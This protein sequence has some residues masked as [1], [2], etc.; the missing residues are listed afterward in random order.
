MRDDEILDRHDMVGL[1][2]V[3]RAG[4]VTSAELL[5]AVTRRVEERNPVLNAV[6]ATRV[7]AA[8]AEVA[9]GLPDGPLRGV[10]FAVKDLLCDVAGMADTA[11]CRL[12]A[13]ATTERDGLLASRYRRAGLV[14]VGKTNTAE[15]GL[16][17]TTEPVLHG[18]T[19]NPWQLDHSPGGSSGGS[20]AAVAGGMFPAAHASDYGGSIRIPAACCGLF[21]LKP[22]R[23]RVPDDHGANAF[24]FPLIASHALTRTVR[25]SAAL[26]DAVA[27][28]LP[29]DPYGALP[30]STA[31]TF[32]AGLD[33]PPRPLRIGVATT[34]ADGNPAHPAA[35]AAVQ[36]TA[37]LLSDQGHQLSA[38]A[39]H[40][41][42]VAEAMS[43]GQLVI[44]FARA[45][46]ADRL[47][48][49]GRDL[50]ADDIEPFTR[51]LL[52]TMPAQSG[53]DVHGALQAVEQIGRQLAPFFTGYDVWLTPTLRVAVPQLG[54]LDTTEP[55]SIFAHGPEMTSFASVFNIGGLPAAS[56]P[57][58]FDDDGLPVGIQ[59]VGPMGAE[60][61]LLRLARQL[62]LAAPWPWQAPAER[63][64]LKKS[65]ETP[66]RTRP[67]R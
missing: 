9:D 36:R 35:A 49:L 4:D 25:D 16:S 14:I 26:L 29:G 37:A 38:A 19:R 44:A 63:L 7:D 56:V 54:V 67:P 47:A 18:P 41:D 33:R 65:R 12:F 11:G 60:E 8:R 27:G 13:G 59:L 52:D 58:G 15:L 6:V 3:I 2:A 5:D 32:L 51:F 21:G 20:A 55:A 30:V 1:A 23:G 46:I 57:A 62:E 48:A 10:P 24:A 66:A 61:I 31:G 34:S 28:P 43:L 39:P 50:A 42:P 17:P 45:Q 40:W 22:S 64:S 53:A